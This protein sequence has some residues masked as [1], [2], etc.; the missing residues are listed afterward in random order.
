MMS[1]LRFFCLL[2]YGMALAGW[3][4]MWT[5]PAAV[6]TQIVALLI[7]GIHVVEVLVAFRLV[8]RYSG[9]LATSIVLTLLFGLLHLRPLIL[10]AKRAAQLDRGGE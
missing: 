4:G 1:L 6:V 5:G 10:Q 2:L 9:G 3:I 8:R 7:V